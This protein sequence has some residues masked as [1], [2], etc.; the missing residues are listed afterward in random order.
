MT[1]RRRGWPHGQVPPARTGLRSVLG[2]SSDV[3]VTSRPGA[4]SVAGNLW[5]LKTAAVQDAPRPRLERGTYRLGG[6]DAI[7]RC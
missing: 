2:A 6:G 5:G 4:A 1:S 3:R 7:S